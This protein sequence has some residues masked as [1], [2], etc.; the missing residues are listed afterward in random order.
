MKR[1]LNMDLSVGYKSNSQ[2][3]RIV[4]ENWGS[5]NLYCPYCGNMKLESYPNNMKVSDFYCPVCKEDFQLKSSAKEFGKT[6]PGAEYYTLID[7]IGKKEQPNLFLVRYSLEEKIVKELTFI[8]KTFFTHSIIEK[9]NPLKETAKRAGWTGSK[10][11][12]D[13]IPI[14]GKFAIL[15][16]ETEIEDQVIITKL[17]KI[18]YFESKNNE[19][20]NWYSEILAIINNLPDE[21]YLEDVYGFEEKMK[22]LFPQNNNIKAKMRQQMQKLRDNGVLIFMK[23]GHYTKSE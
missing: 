14:E 17:K 6:Y 23:R 20:I 13:L 10:I 3:A 4:T 21:F 19:E 12:L 15:T 2:I 22:K 7:K 16:S 9:R 1:E 5:E 11:L 8:P 18:S